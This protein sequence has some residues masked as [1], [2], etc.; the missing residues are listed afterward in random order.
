MTDY[1]QD[2]EYTLERVWFDYLGGCYVG[3]GL[4]RWSP[5]GGFHLDAFLERS[6]PPLPPEI[7]VGKVRLL[8]DAEVRSI[9]MKPEAYEWAVAT[10]PLTDRVDL[11]LQNRLSV[12]LASV[13]FCRKDCGPAG[14]ARSDSA[15]LAT[16]PTPRMPDTVETEERLAGKILRKNYAL[17]GI[18]YADEV[19]T[20]VGRRAGD[21][22]LEL[23]WKLVRGR[24]ARRQSW[25]WPTAFR[26]ALSIVSGHAVVLLQRAVRRGAYELVQ[27]RRKEAVK[28]LGL[29]SLL[30]PGPL[31]DK[32]LLAKLAEFL[33]RPGDSATVCR[34]IFNQTLAAAGQGT[35]Q[36]MELLLSTILE[37]ALRTLDKRPFKPGDRSW[38]IDSSMKRFRQRYLSDNW[39]RH[40][41]HALQ[42]HRRLR[43]RNAHPDWLSG[44]GGALSDEEMSK[45]LDD[46]IFLARFY[47]YMILAIAGFNDIRPTFP[48]PHKEWGPS[49][50]VHTGSSENGPGPGQDVGRDPEADAALGGR[51]DPG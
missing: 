12:D 17:G 20:L 43:H 26:D 45:S 41:E 33:V 3:R 4:M 6:G 5:D 22:V 44:H 39:R 15:L 38:R 35:W 50:T 31:V 2:T 1:F 13:L 29:L 10:V 7:Q 25:A 46:M 24:G 27:V 40:C 28:S 30:N 14:S 8:G 48:K 9:R 49:L 21:S 42:V 51:K 16:G 47:G 19:V 18:S 34:A 11:T 37:A 32:E 36:A 23:T